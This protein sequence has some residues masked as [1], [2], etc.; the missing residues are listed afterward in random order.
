MRRKDG[1]IAFVGV[2]SAFG[3]LLLG[4]LIMAAA[5]NGGAQPRSQTATAKT[6][7]AVGT[8][9][10]I[11]G[12]TL[13]LT[14]D[15]G[16]ELNVILPADVKVLRVSPGS[17]DLKDAAPIELSDLKGGD[18]ILVRGKLADDGKTFAAATVVAMKKEELAEK[19]AHEKEEWQKHGIG[20]LVKTVDAAS[21]VVTIGVMSAAGSK[22]RKSTRLNSSHRL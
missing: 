16:T 6:P 15:T 21:G 9:K 12:N 10:A 11:S 20:G 5:D 19:A 13:T 22:D 4:L 17:K 1:R 18:R 7:P 8:I 2:G 3:A 14:M